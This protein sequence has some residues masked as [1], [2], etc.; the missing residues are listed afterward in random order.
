M[1]TFITASQV[2][3]STLINEGDNGMHKYA[4]RLEWCLRGIKKL[5]YDTLPS[6]KSVEVDVNDNG[7]IDLPLDCVKF[8]R[9]GIKNGDKIFD[10]TQNRGGAFPINNYPNG[11]PK[12]DPHN[13]TYTPI[14]QQ[15]TYGY[16]N[17]ILY[18]FPDGQN[19]GRRFGNGGGVNPRGYYRFWADRNQLVL[20]QIGN[21]KKIYLEYVSNGMTA[22]GETLVDSL[23]EDF[24]IAWIE[25]QDRKYKKDNMYQDYER[26]AYNE[27]RLLQQ[28]LGSFSKRDILDSLRKSF[29]MAIKY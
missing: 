23:A 6:L 13:F 16:L 14:E 3:Q 1:A 19:L 25:Y 5:N 26:V 8:S 18:R 21:R 7:T 12:P 9:V 11:D 17:S 10:L 4:Q 27:L 22:T 28:R 20:Y 2:V 24:L 15:L 29:K